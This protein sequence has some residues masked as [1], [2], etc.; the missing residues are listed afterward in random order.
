MG[1]QAVS[2]PKNLFPEESRTPAPYMDPHQARRRAPTAYENELADA[3]E[4]AFGDD[5]R[6]LD[7]LVARLNAD[8]VRT[9]DGLEWTSDR[10]QSVMQRLGE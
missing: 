10:F 7:A 2:A 3:L 5:V 4:A 8:G 9:P 6:E 1:K